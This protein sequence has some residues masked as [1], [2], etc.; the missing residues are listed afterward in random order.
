MHCKS[1]P[2]VAIYLAQVS[3]CRV[4]RFLLA[5]GIATS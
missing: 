3:G 1:G 4:H 2:G 5:S